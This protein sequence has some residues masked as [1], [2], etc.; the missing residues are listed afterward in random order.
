LIFFF[1]KSFGGNNF[2]TCWVLSLPTVFLSPQR[3][4]A[5]IFNSILQMHNLGLGK[6]VHGLPELLQIVNGGLYSGVEDST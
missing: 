1:N 5:G 6:R 3:W 4:E 2:I